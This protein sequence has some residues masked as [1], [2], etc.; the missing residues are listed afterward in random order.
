MNILLIDNN[1]SFTYNIREMLRQLVKT[2]FTTGKF[3]IKVRS[4][5]D[6]AIEE[7]T[8]ADKIIISPGPGLPKDYP[9]LFSFL[10]RYSQCK[11]ILG[12]CMGH[13]VICEYFGGRLFNL[14]NVVHGQPKEL[15]ILNEDTALFQGLRSMR[16]GLYHSW[17]VERIS[18]PDEIEVTA[19]SNEE[20]VMA[21]EHKH[22]DIHFVQF[23]PESYI[24][25]DGIKILENFIK[26]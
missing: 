14:E 22:L 17:A 9:V 7:A 3:N 26:N 16:V 5:D 2:C 10:K 13:Q 25:G 12:I 4:V 21:V 6:F 24:T 18:L 8:V 11:S 20:L 1:D 15:Q 23:H 19:L